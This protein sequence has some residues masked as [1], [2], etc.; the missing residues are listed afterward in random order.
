[1]DDAKRFC[2][3]ELGLKGDGWK[4]DASIKKID[5][6]AEEQN[7]LQYGLFRRFA[8]SMHPTGLEGLDY[9]DS[10]QNYLLTA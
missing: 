10:S 9:Q 8:A 5:G 1:L 4:E 3:Q 2:E 6:L 7:R